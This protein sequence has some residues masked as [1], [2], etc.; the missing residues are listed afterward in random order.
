[1][2]EGWTVGMKENLGDRGGEGGSLLLLEESGRGFLLFGDGDK[3]NLG[4]LKIILDFNWESCMFF[5]T[6]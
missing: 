1:M 2:I 6:V 5:G 4:W 3:F